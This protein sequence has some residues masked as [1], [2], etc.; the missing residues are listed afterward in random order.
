MGPAQVRHVDRAEMLIEAYPWPGNVRELQNV[1]ERSVIVCDSD[2]F[3][4][5]DSWLPSGLLGRAHP[6]VDGGAGTLEGIQRAHVMRVLEE[7]NW[8]LGGP[9]GATARLGVK[10]TTLQSLLKRLGIPSPPAAARAS[11]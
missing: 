1:V 8:M 6:G 11:A 3:S 7:T 10:R 4:I 2:V 9:R 5:D